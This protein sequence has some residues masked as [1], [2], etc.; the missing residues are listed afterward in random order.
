M[1][2]K[3]APALPDLNAK[4]LRFALVRSRFNDAITMELMQTCRAELL[5]LGARESDI[6]IRE[7]PGALEIAQ[8][9]QWLAKRKGFDA[10]IGLGCVI[11]G[12]TYHFEI[13]ANTSANAL[14]ALALQSG[15]AVVNAVLTVENLRQAKQRARVKGTEAARVAVEMANL[16]REI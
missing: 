15:L 14:S 9:L 16:R 7:V 5:R 8:A 11:R 12:E 6:V 2:L 1:R 3:L 10:L 13:V 4:G